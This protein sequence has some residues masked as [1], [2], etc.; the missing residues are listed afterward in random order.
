MFFLLNQ[1]L[2]EYLGADGDSEDQ[3]TKVIPKRKAT[4]IE[5]N[6]YILILPLYLI[7]YSTI[8][9][10]VY[11]TPLFT[12]LTIFFFTLNL[13]FLFLSPI[14]YL[15][16]KRAATTKGASEYPKHKVDPMKFLRIKAKII[17]AVKVYYTQDC[18]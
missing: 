8:Y 10:S 1:D 18:R 6:P 16:K 7:I 11:L 12:Y 9:F 17:K 5:N 14:P 4:R 13:Y 2:A 15:R 3:T